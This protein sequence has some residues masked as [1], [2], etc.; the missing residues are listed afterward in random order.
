MHER[1]LDERPFFIERGST[2]RVR[3]RA[4][5]KC[6]Q[7]GFLVVLISN[8]RGYNAGAFL[9][10]AT[11]CD[12]SRRPLT[13]LT[14]GVAHLLWTKDLQTGDSS[15]VS[16]GEN[17]TPSLWRGCH[18]PAVAGAKRGR[19]VDHISRT[20]WPTA[21]SRFAGF[22]T[23]HYAAAPERK[24]PA[25]AGLFATLWHASMTPLASMACA[26]A[27]TSARRRGSRSP[28]R[29]HSRRSASSSLPGP[30]SRSEPCAGG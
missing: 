17:L 25:W 20:M 12:V 28:S 11:H 27:A 9:V 29:A 19:D 13:Q 4:L 10:F 8:A 26:V 3:Q 23:S 14:D 22:D 1:A 6:L 21:S 7:I 18:V 24:R 16:T 2:V 30:P 15:V 5:T